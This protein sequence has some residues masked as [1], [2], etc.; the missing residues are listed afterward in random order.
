VGLAIEVFV[1]QGR[2]ESETFSFHTEKSASYP[3]EKIL[4]VCGDA[5]WD[6]NVSDRATA[7][8]KNSC[9]LGRDYM[10]DTGLPWRTIVPF[11]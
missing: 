10:N 4:Y 7:D 8:I 6:I 3:A 11:F 5:C 2:F 1:S 9:N